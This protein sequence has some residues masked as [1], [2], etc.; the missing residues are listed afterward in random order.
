MAL[1]VFFL[2][3]KMASGIC[4]DQLGCSVKHP[5][6]IA[7]VCLKVRDVKQFEC[8]HLENYYMLVSTVINLYW[9]DA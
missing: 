9:D 6:Q 5:N 2:E 1:E 8:D 3:V 7:F 4:V